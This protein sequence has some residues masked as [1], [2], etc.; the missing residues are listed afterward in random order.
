MAFL[1]LPCNFRRPRAILSADRDY[2]PNGANTGL[3]YGLL[4]SVPRASK[5][6]A[7][8]T[9][10]TGI[11]LASLNSATSRFRL[12]NG[13]LRLCGSRLDASSATANGL[14]MLPSSN[15]T[16]GWTVTP[17]DS[18]SVPCVTAA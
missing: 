13:R 17:D 6:T 14:V 2:V 3:L 8:K 15:A 12:D 9:I 11:K 18:A 4:T 5:Q 16:A 10:G 1:L 7:M